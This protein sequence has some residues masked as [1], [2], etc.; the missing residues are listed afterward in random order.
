MKFYYLIISDI[1]NY[2]KIWKS[3]YLKIHQ[4]FKSKDFIDILSNFFDNLPNEIYINDIQQ[5]NI[6]KNYY[7]NQTETN[8]SD[9]KLIWNREISSCFA[10]FCD[11]EKIIEIYLSNFNAS[12]VANM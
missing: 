9:V 4:K 7:F 6:T 11:C 2:F 10:M 8:I 3:Y 5:R 1:I 12:R